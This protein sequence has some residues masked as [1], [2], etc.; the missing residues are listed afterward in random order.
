MK[1]NTLIIDV[2]KILCSQLI[3]LHHFL[4]Y[5]AISVILN[6]IL[7]QNGEVVFEYSRMVVQIFLV[8][9]GFLAISTISKS[10]LTSLKSF[11]KLIIKRYIRLVIPFIVGITLAVI[12]SFIARQIYIED[13]IP[14][15]PTFIQL[16]SHI[17]FLHGL[18]GVD[19]LSS[20]VWYVA[21]DF[22]LFLALSFIVYFSKNKATIS[23]CILLMMLS[24]FWF[25]RDSSYDNYLV[26]F[27]GAYGIG[28]LS[29]LVNTNKLKKV[30]FLIIL[31]LCSISLLV[32]FRERILIALCAGWLLSFNF[33]LDKVLNCERINKA[34]QKLS[35]ISYTLFL[36]HFSVLIISNT[37]FNVYEWPKNNLTIYLFGVWVICMV[38]AFIS[39]N[40]SNYI[41]KKVN[42]LSIKN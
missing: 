31:I 18:L 28:V 24:L 13:Y 38:L 4:G 35:E 34:I 27:F 5:G 10:N 12:S 25:N 17:F 7:G 39:N 9:A 14:N 22:Q 6:Q 21:I 36:T 30:N 11:I 23:I 29:G 32:E 15:A 2:L 3:V 41:T 1:Q 20:G 26:Y 40:F 42:H 19:S 8:I 16:V 33:N 37:I